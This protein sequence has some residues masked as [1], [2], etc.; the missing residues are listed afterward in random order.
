MCK[1]FVL[2]ACEVESA[3]LRFSLSPKS[4]G[5][6]CQVVWEASHMLSRVGTVGEVPLT[7][8]HDKIDL[9]VEG[10]RELKCFDALD[11]VTN[12]TQLGTA[13]VFPDVLESLL[14]P[15]R[16]MTTN[17]ATSVM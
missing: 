15:N 12:K 10:K 5:P 2:H 9:E 14:Q 16:A 6:C 3:F 4:L 7:L 17:C 8:K 11:T 13:Q 1:Q